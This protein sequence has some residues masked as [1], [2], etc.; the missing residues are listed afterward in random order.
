[1]IPTALLLGWVGRK[2]E[3]TAFLSKENSPPLD[4]PVPP[5]QEFLTVY[6]CASFYPFVPS[7][8]TSDSVA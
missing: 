3:E 1:M 7:K 4:A 2:E 5:I 6:L 8:G